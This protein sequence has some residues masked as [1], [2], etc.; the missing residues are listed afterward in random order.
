MILK[1]TDKCSSTKKFVS[2][3][4]RRYDTFRMSRTAPI[5]TRKLTIGARRLES[6]VCGS[7]FGFLSRYS[8]TFDSVYDTCTSVRGIS[9][10]KLG[11]L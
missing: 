8:A 1:E 4:L 6:D 7:D 11:V 10:A 9:A 3:Q 2:N 5:D